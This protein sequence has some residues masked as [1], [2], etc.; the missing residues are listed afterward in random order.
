MTMDWDEDS[1]T[2][3]VGGNFSGFRVDLGKSTSSA[4]SAL[5]WKHEGFELVPISNS[6]PSQSEV[7]RLSAI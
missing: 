7:R 3:W 2:I 5:K 6:I 4:F 1:K